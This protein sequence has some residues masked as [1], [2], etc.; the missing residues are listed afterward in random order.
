[1]GFAE[2]AGLTRLVLVTVSVVMC[3][4]SVLAMLTEATEREPWLGT[5]EWAVD[6]TALLTTASLAF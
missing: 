5:E 2:I 4:F 6:T 3:L 1:M